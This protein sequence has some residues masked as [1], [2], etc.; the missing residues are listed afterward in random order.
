[1]TTT[2]FDKV[3]G[4]GGIGVGLL[5][6]TDDNRTLGRNESRLV[7]LSDAKDYCKQHIVLYYAAVLL[8]GVAQVYP[9]GCVGCDA[10]GDKLL[11]EMVSAGMSVQYVE[12][13]ETL[14]TTISCC[15]QYPDKDGCNFTSQNGAGV[16][17][18]SENIQNALT[19]I[20]VDQRTVL[21][22]IPEVSVEAR[23]KMLS[24]G[25]IMGGYCTLSVPE[26]EVDAFERVGAFRYCNL[27]T[28]NEREALALAPGNGDDPEA[29]T[30]RLYAKLS[31]D[32][33]DA[34][35]VVTCGK[36]GAYT[37]LNGRIEFVPPLLAE[38]INTTGAGDAFWGGILAGLAL[39]FPLQKGRNDR[40]F[41]DSEITSAAELGS[42]CAG[43]AVESADSIAYHVHPMSIL[44]RISSNHWHL[45]PQFEDYFKSMRRTE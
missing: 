41:G 2:R 29:L 27:L 5:F 18:T 37:L 34:A 19:A 42:L 23:V 4:T 8:S 16:R 20:G 15:L 25:R 13:D 32:N 44:E 24:E 6:E 22:V 35:L 31:Q 1:M 7:T 30:L 28:V 26:S 9:V 10:N 36:R 3:I 14:P 38:V 43:M 12:R 45:S 17:V 33:P 39:G 11:S 21:A 40:F